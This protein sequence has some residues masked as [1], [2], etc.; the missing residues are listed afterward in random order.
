MGAAGLQRR[1]QALAMRMS[2]ATFGVIAEALGV[3]TA[4]ARDLVQDAHKRLASVDWSVY[5]IDRIL[6]L[7]R[8]GYYGLTRTDQ[9]RLREIALRFND[10]LSEFYG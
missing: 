4:R 5:D 8:R 9:V 7:D 1:E 10:R 6:R 2:G 3:C